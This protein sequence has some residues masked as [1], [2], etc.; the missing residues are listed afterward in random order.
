MRMARIKFK[1]LSNAV[2]QSSQTF[3]KHRNKGYQKFRA[4]RINVKDHRKDFKTT[5][6]KLSGNRSVS[7]TLVDKKKLKKNI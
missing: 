3:K 2:K 5:K 4:K 7:Q 1:G 6:P